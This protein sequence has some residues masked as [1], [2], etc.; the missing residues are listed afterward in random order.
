MMSWGLLTHITQKAGLVLIYP[1]LLSSALLHFCSRQTLLMEGDITH[2]C[3]QPGCPHCRGNEDS[4]LPG[5]AHQRP[6][7]TQ[8]ACTGTCA[9]PELVIL[10]YS[11]QVGFTCL[12]WG[13]WRE[14]ERKKGRNRCGVEK[15]KLWKLHPPGSIL[16]LPTGPL[17]IVILCPW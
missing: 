17:L 5:C 13:A 8:A 6:A 3:S 1:C 14:G 15:K 10:G 12:P 11:G 16:H 7:G 2:W 9:C 4:S